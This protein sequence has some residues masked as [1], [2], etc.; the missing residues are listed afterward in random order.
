MACSQVIMQP[1]NNSL[2]LAPLSMCHATLPSLAVGFHDPRRGYSQLPGSRSHILLL[3]PLRCGMLLSSNLL[4][5]ESRLAWPPSMVTLLAR[6][7]CP[8]CWCPQ[9]VFGSPW[10]RHRPLFLLHA[11][12]LCLTLC[13]AAFTVPAPRTS[14][15]EF[16][17][18]LG[19]G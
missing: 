15:L 12:T 16:W 10:G 14:K 11:S 8:F 1:P 3:S 13:S 7:L 9:W 4:H 17:L 2:P 6:A 5:T 18:V 19:R